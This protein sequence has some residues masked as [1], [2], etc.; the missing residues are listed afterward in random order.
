M[1]MREAGAGAI[2]N[3]A[4][5]ASLGLTPYHSPEYAA[6]KAGLIRFTSTLTDLGAVRVNCLVPD[7][8]AT[9]RVTEAERATDPP[10]LPL[11]TVADAT[12]QLIRDESL[13]GRVL[14]LD[15]GKPPRLLLPEATSW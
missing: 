8:V 5:T 15:R 6:A 4:S 13:A 1:A 11:A 10:P 14:I 2:V 7:W 3:I 9:E 12:L